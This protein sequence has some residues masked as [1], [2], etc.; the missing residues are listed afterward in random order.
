M[1][2]SSGKL[3]WDGTGDIPKNFVIKG[4]LSSIEGVKN[5]VPEKLCNVVDD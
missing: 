4:L 1:E 3:L 5:T 2:P